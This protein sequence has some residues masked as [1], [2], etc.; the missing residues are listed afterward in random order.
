MGEY[1]RG[2][3]DYPSQPCVAQP[4]IGKLP[5]GE[6]S[7]HIV[8]FVRTMI[9]AMAMSPSFG[10]RHCLPLQ[11]YCVWQSLARRGATIVCAAPRTE[12]KSP[13]SK[14]AATELELLERFTVVVPDTLLLQDIEKIE[15]PKA[16]TVSSAVLTGILRN[17]SGLQEYKVSVPQPII[18]SD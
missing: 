7:H 12:Y 9:M 10:S 14:T 8:N 3:L 4:R 18:S 15:T 5:A 11:R 6:N 17:P 1:E 2:V 13:S 16:A